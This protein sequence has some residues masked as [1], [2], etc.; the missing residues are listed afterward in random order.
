[1]RPLRPA[2]RYSVLPLLRIPERQVVRRRLVR[3]AEAFAGPG[4]QVQVLA[5]LAAEGPVGVGGRVHTVAAAGRAAHD[6]LLLRC[7]HELPSGTERQLEGGV[8]A[9]GLHALG[10]EI[11][12]ITD[13]PNG[14]YAS[15]GSK[16]MSVPNYPDPQPPLERTGAGDAFSSTFVA[17]IAVGESLETALLWS[18][19]N[20]MNVVQHV[21]AQKGLLTKD[22][23]EKYLAEAPDWYKVKEIE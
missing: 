11:V 23:L 5:A 3:H 19:I 22:V 2:V 16:V 17:A 1:M 9:A 21:G 13:G 14:S 4:A 6:A 12:V 15:D 10:S 18:P 8:V 20:S 7:R